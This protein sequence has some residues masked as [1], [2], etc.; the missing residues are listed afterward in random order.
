M[1][2]GLLSLLYLAVPLLA[3]QTRVVINADVPVAPVQGAAVPVA[4]ISLPKMELGGQP[5]PLR[6]G[7]PAAVLTAKL[8][9]VRIRGVAV[10]GIAGAAAAKPLA[11]AARGEK[12][13]EAGGIDLQ[14]ADAQNDNALTK[15][16]PS[17]AGPN[18]A[19]GGELQLRETIGA[20]FDGVDRVRRQEVD[21]FSEPITETE[22]FGSRPGL[23]LDQ[24]EATRLTRHADD[25][26]RLRG[27]RATEGEASLAAD[28]AAVLRG[29]DDLARAVALGRTTPK[30]LKAAAAIVERMDL[31]K[32][33]KFSELSDS[34]LK[35]DVASK[36]TPFARIGNVEHVEQQLIQP[37][38]EDGAEL[39]AAFKSNRKQS[40]EHF[41]EMLRAL[42][43]STD[44]GKQQVPDDMKAAL[45]RFNPQAETGPNW[46]I[47]NFILTHEYASMQITQDL[48]KQA[49]FTAKETW[50]FQKLI[51][52]HNFGPDLT[53]KKNA[54]MR[55]H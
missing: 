20:A 32:L 35:T 34:F 2:P 55:E 50:A 12:P 42:Q 30:E 22:L 8:G 29:I 11:G 36:S 9:E 5:V 52:N 14:G 4:P 39:A 10:A 53:D 54:A 17:T 1:T 37:L 41:V 3:Q 40:V 45:L 15:V 51:A 33:K 21:V 7:P 49:G 27:K 44:L 43:Y 6:F 26:A 48:G 24:K 38:A 23:A 25:T 19:G 16:I 18:A 46:Y 28:D 13:Q 47:N 31:A